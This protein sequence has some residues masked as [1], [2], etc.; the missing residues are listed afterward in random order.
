MTDPELW[1]AVAEARSP[2]TWAAVVA[3]VL[4]VYRKSDQA[5]RF[6]CSVEAGMSGLIGYAVGP[7]SAAWAGVNE[8]LGTLLMTS[9]GYLAL[10]VVAS[11]V[12]DRSTIRELILRLVGG[13]KDG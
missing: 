8:A 7:D 2:E 11:I 10:D 5:S 3:G 9:M 6:I 12:A 1:R 4:Y 13:K